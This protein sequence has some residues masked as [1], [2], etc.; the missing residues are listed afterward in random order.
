MNKSHTP[1]N[2][3]NVATRLFFRFFLCYFAAAPI[4]YLLAI[5]GITAIQA[6]TAGK[7][8]F[9]LIPLALLGGLLTVTKPYLLILTA[10]KAFFDTAL[11]YRVTVWARTDLI[12]LLPWN[13]CFLMVVLSLLL[14]AFAAARAELFTFW[15]TKRDAQL[16]FSRAFGRFL[17]EI[18]LFLAI[19][20]SQY[21]LWPTILEK[22]GMTLLP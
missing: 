6:N 4:G 8:E 19:A 9:L 15:N 11:L 3:E 22:F 20:L 12:G 18:I 14:F 1:T 17:T 13:I 2:G 21:Y 5:R 10:V 7:V 16:I